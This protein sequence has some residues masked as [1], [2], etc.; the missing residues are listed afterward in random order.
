MSP[1]AVT[2]RVLPHGCRATFR[3][4]TVTL[5]AG[6]PESLETIGRAVM[7]VMATNGITA[8]LFQASPTGR[9][10]EWSL[11]AIALAEAA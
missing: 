3:G 9:S 11:V 6:R 4:T 7:A 5:I 10:G 1:A 8:T 2:V